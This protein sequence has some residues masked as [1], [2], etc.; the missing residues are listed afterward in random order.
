MYSIYIK[1]SNSYDN[2]PQLPVSSERKNNISALKPPLFGMKFGRGLGCVSTL[3]TQQTKQP[4]GC[5]A[6]STALST[7]ARV[8]HRQPGSPLHG[9]R[10]LPLAPVSLE[11]ALALYY[12]HKHLFFFKEISDIF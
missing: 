8:L 3:P 1:V 4:P 2:T 11:R 12:S 6:P 10:R 9:K 7:A 5:A